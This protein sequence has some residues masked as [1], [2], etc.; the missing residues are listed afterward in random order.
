MYL[1]MCVP[2]VRASHSVHVEVKGQPQETV[3]TFHL[4][5]HKSVLLPPHM[6]GYLAGDLLGICL[7]FLS[8]C[9]KTSSITYPV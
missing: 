8:A 9:Y 3:F 5:C 2:Q 1:F 4:V 7:C 6:P